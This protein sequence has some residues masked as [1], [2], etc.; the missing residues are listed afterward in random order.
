M[1]TNALKYLFGESKLLSDDR[2]KWPVKI[3]PEIT[4]YVICYKPVSPQDNDFI[5]NILKACKIVDNYQIV[6][7]TQ[8]SYSAIINACPGIQQIFLFG[9]NFK[10]INI[11]FVQKQVDHL[12]LDGRQVFSLPEASVVSQNAQM[13]NYFWQKILKPIYG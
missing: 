13:K 11:Q 8:Q 6:H 7:F 1:E 2:V 9:V 12:D 5:V 3:P 4:T 10:D